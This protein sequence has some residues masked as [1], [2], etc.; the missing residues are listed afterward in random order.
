MCKFSS[1]WNDEERFFLG[2]RS[3]KDL[4]IKVVGDGWY[5]VS[6]VG[7]AEAAWAPSV[8]KTCIRKVVLELCK[9]LVRSH[10]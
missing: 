4:G 6:T 9:S 3:L 1:Q 5:K 7:K 2:E 10:L 8:F